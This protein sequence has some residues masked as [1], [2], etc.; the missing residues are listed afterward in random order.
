MESTLGEFARSKISEVIKILED[1]N[2]RAEQ[3][4][5]YNENKNKENKLEF[6]DY[7]Y[8]IIEM[9]GEP[10]IRTKL[11]KMYEVV[12]PEKSKDKIG[13]IEKL[14]SEIDTLKLQIE[15]P[16]DYEEALEKIRE[17]IV[18]YQNELK[19]NGEQNDKN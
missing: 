7:I 6:K 13:I 17:Q 14:K 3:E 5:K 18:G 15:N 8:N 4:K 12:Y 9:I 1:E 16:E 2:F 11:H 10:I 19:N